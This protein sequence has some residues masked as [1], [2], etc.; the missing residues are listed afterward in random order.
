[1]KYCILLFI[2]LSINVNAEVKKL[3]PEAN[4]SITLTGKVL[5]IS[6]ESYP[7][8]KNVPRKIKIKTSNGVYNIVNIS[9]VNPNGLKIND[10]VN[11]KID[12]YTYSTDSLSFNKWITPAQKKKKKSHELIPQKSFS[13][14]K[15]KCYEAYNNNLEMI[16]ELSVDM[17]T[18]KQ[19]ATIQ[20]KYK[21]DIELAI[22]C[23]NGDQY[24]NDRTMNNV[25]MMQKCYSYAGTGARGMYCHLSN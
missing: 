23:V 18:S 6:N 2:L 19:A 5:E 11:V 4:E 22:D 20:K 14:I 15:K 1:M 24:P 13:N 9:K 3:C 17:V 7:H 16:K 10:T 12:C 21:D 25:A 8:K